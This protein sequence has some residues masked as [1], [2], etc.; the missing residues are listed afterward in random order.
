MGSLTAPCSAPFSPGHK[1]SD[2]KAQGSRI[3]TQGSRL[4]AQSSRLKASEY[5]AQGSRGKA[6]GRTRGYSTAGAGGGRRN[7]GRHVLPFVNMLSKRVVKAV[8]AVRLRKLSLAS[9]QGCL[10]I[11]GI[12]LE[13]TC[14]AE[15]ITQV[16]R[17]WLKV[18]SVVFAFRWW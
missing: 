17:N 4:K 12:L 6:T 13:R 18:V 15:R 2:Y 8:I 11:L 1:A 7:L 5:K 3:K 16:G 9:W 14:A 10:E